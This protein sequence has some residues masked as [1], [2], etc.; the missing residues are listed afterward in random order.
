[1]NT[2]YITSTTEKTHEKILESYKHLF[3]KGDK[4]EIRNNFCKKILIVK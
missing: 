4:I 1:M 3:K 2:K